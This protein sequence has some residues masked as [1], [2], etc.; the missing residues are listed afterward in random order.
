MGGKQAI[1]LCQSISSVSFAMKISI[2]VSS[3]KL[4]EIHCPELTWCAH[5][6]FFITPV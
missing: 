3:I 1:F 6:D 4:T 2:E 5:T